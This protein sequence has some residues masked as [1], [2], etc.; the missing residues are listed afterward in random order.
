MVFVEPKMEILSFDKSDL[1]ASSGCTNQCH[2]LTCTNVCVDDG[3]AP[4]IYCPGNECY[5]H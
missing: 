4:N 5:Q 2:N 1:V 3:C